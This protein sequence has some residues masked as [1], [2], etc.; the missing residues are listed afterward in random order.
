MNKREVVLSLL[1]SKQT[2]PYV[3]AAF[4]LHFSHEYHAGQSAVDKHLEYFRPTGMDFGKIQHEAVFPRIPDIR[5]P[6]DWEKM[7]KYGRDFYA[8][9]LKPVEGLVKAAKSADDIIRT[10]YSP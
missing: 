10:S 7:P 4:F 5:T 9:H 6:D 8:G 3:P 1:D 2:L